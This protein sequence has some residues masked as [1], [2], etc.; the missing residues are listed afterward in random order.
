MVTVLRL[1]AV[2]AA[3]VWVLAGCSA[4]PAGA[5]PT[6]GATTAPGSTAPSTSGTPILPDGR[7]PVIL[8]SFDLAHRTV[9]FDLIELYLGSQ[10][11]VEWQKD[12]P[13]VTEVPALNGSYIRNNNPRLRTLPVAGT[14]IVRVLNE[15]GDPSL[16]NLIAFDELPGYHSYRGVFWITVTGGI[17]TMFE[18]QFFP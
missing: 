9:T 14:V 11:A 15:N 13:G 1:A 6:A 16:T 18:E 10:A 2:G 12:H 7:S 5:P 17:V 4:G 8:K 3:A